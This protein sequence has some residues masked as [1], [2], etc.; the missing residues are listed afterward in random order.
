QA[1]LAHGGEVR[2]AVGHVGLTVVLVIAL[3]SGTA[4]FA[5]SA[6]R[7]LAAWLP[8]FL[9]GVLARKLLARGT[10]AV[11]DWTRQGW[12][13]LA[14]D[15]SA[16]ARVTGLDRRRPA[17]F[18]A[19]GGR[20]VGGV[21]SLDR[22]RLVV[23]LLC[24]LD[25]ALIGRGLTVW[26]PELLPRFGGAERV[27]AIGIAI[28]VVASMVDVLQVAVRRRQRRLNPRLQTRLP[29]RVEGRRVGVV[30]LS[31]AGFGARSTADDGLE[32]GAE[33]E[34]RIG[35]PAPD[36][37]PDHAPHQSVDQPVWI[38]GRAIVRSLVPTGD[39]RRVGAE[40]TTLD[41]AG[42]EQLIAYCAVGH[43]SGNGSE[44]VDLTPGQ[45][46]AEASGR[47]AVKVGSG[48][49]AVLGMVGLLLGPAALPSLAD[50]AAP[51]TTCVSSAEGEPAEGALVRFR[52]DRHWHRA[53]L[54][55]ADGCLTAGMPAR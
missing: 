15:L 34:V 43:H 14:G 28:V 20:T 35:L 38:R 6:P 17:W 30:D 46:R 10:M 52:Y 9:L 16:V 32:V 19:G 37:T 4:P 12:R 41:P 13:T 39:R 49:G 29:G 26:W 47:G 40:F 11:G 44:P 42:R 23:G 1:Q 50:V 25:L 55:G 22:M 24:I 21:S 33:V 18:A 45:F 2:G 36:H 3:L 48:I 5:S 54:T 27:V 31:P 51:V 7:W 8:T 53:G